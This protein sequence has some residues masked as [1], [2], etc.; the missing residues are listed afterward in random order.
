M[1]TE[2]N[3][4]TPPNSNKDHEKQNIL[5]SWFAG[6]ND[7]NPNPSFADFNKSQENAKKILVDN[8]D[9]EK[10][11]KDKP[12]PTS[13]KDTV[14]K[15]TKTQPEQL[16]FNETIRRAK[17]AANSIDPGK[18]KGMSESNAIKYAQSSMQD[19]E[20]K[21]AA[22]ANLSSFASSNNKPATP[23]Q[24]NNISS[25]NNSTNNTTNVTNITTDYLRGIRSH[26]EST[27]QWRSNIG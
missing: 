25:S 2:S 4:P 10:P 26:Y 7:I 24:P 27:P 16:S 11:K 19:L 9:L 5:N 1:A 22:V 12:K 18:I 23:N 6:N 3:T 17:A 8:K 15:P 14:H 13:F 20:Q 21:M